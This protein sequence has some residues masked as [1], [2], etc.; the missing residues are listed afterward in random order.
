MTRRF[1]ARVC[2][3][4]ATIM[5]AYVG[6][7]LALSRSGYRQ[8]DRLNI[9]GFYFVTPTDPCSRALNHALVIVYYPLVLAERELGTGRLPARDP[10]D[11]LSTAPE[12][13]HDRGVWGQSANRGV[14]VSERQQSLG[15]ENRTSLIVRV[16]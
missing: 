14:L 4:F 3:A 10:D 5:V 9:K 11:A 15:H 1:D 13:A 2:V 7:Y 8:A 6:S 12:G 16:G